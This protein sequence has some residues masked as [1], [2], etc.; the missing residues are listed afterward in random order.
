MTTQGSKRGLE[1]EIKEVRGQAPGVVLKKKKG[2]SERR[3]KFGFF[4]FSCIIYAQVLGTGV[5]WILCMYP[6]I[7]ID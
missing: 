5:T 2:E 4:I 7:K 1:K 6:L 3:R